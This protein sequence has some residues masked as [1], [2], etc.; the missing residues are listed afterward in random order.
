MSVTRNTRNIAHTAYTHR[1]VNGQYYRSRS[2]LVAE[3]VVQC[4]K[5]AH[6]SVCIYHC[7]EEMCLLSG[8]ILRHHHSPVSMEMTLSSLSS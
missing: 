1:P 4:V 5:I 7:V 2:S 6:D 3:H 8:S